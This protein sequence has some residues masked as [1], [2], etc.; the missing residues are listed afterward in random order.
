VA[1]GIAAAILVRRIGCSA[2]SHAFF[3]DRVDIPSDDQVLQV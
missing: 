1:A 3:A 2:F